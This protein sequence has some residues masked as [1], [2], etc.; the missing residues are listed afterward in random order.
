[1]DLGARLGQW[2]AAGLG[3]RSAAVDLGSVSGKQRG[4]VSGRQQRIRELN[5]VS[6]RQ[7]WI[8]KIGSDKDES[9]VSSSGL[10]SAAPTPSRFGS[11]ARSVVG[12]DRQMRSAAEDS[13]VQLS[14]RLAA[15]D[16]EDRLG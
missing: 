10:S 15:V 1:M 3:Q 11:L 9:A 8:R 13:G 16:S 12:S 14:Q 7:Q 5:S 6:G 4:S 2:L